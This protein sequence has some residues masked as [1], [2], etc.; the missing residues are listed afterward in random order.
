MI[1]TASQQSQKTNQVKK[2]SVLQDRSNRG[3]ADLIGRKGIGLLV[4]CK[5]L[6]ELVEKLHI[7]I[8]KQST[9]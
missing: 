4:L 7:H 9:L 3:E 8:L 6:C 5:S 2:G 1:S